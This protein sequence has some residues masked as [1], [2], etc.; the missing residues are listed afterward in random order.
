M[1]EDRLAFAE[2]AV[3][4]YTSYPTA[5]HFHAGIDA[6]VYASWLAALAPDAS[7]SLYLH[8]PFCTTLCTY[9]GC[10]TQ[11]VNRREPID[12]YLEGLLAEV[13]LVASHTRARRV[14]RI[15]WGGGTPT[16]LGLPGM[17]QVMAHIAARFDLSGLAEHAIELDPRG[18]DQE[19]ARGLARLGIT[20]A[21][22]GAQDFNADVQHAIGR[23]Q[24]FDVVKAGVAHLRAAGVHSINLDLMYGLPHQDSDKLERSLLLA[25]SL[26]PDRIALF[27]YAHVP[28]MRKQQKLINEEWL[29]GAQARLEQAEAARRLLA[30]LGYTAIGLDHFTLPDDA[31]AVAARQGRLG[32]NFQGYTDDAADAIIGLGCS[33][34]GSLPQGFVQNQ[35]DT[36]GYR[37]TIKQ[38]RFATVRGLELTEDDRRRGAVIERL[39]CDFSVIVPA[40]LLPDALPT[41]MPLMEAGMVL[42][43]GRRVTMTAR[44]RPFVRV[45]AAAFDAWLA[46]AG[47]HSAAV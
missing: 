34:I 13:E 35:P 36:R 21:S 42:V 17:E 16:M 5:P 27:G 10:H 43:R 32:R 15:H 33:S 20:R 45:V 4:R 2:R 3:P 7:L 47:R 31:L 44:G 37:N 1:S 6:D 29:P 18:L 46:K 9:C 28:W 19:L 26:A 24:P 38:G 30:G 8:V 40:D 23:I 39:M 41:L 12:A 22:L 25:H 14:T 11:A